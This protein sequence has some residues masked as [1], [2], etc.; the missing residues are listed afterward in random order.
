MRAVEMSYLGGACG[1]SRLD[2]LRNE[3]VYERCGTSGRGSGVGCGV[4]EWV[5]KSTLR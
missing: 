4:V 3:S 5:K 2:G 1:V